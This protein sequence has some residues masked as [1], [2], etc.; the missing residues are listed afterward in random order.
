MAMA[1]RP[2]LI[3]V[4]LP[5]AAFLGLRILGL[6]QEENAPTPDSEEYQ[7]VKDTALWVQVWLGERKL[8]GKLDAAGNF[9]PDKRY[10]FEKG[11]PFSSIPPARGINSPQKGV[12]EFRSGR[13]IPG[14][15]DDD[16]NFIPTIGGRIIDFKDYR[17]SPKAPNYLQPSREV[18]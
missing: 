13:L 4:I 1:A 11:Q 16:G 7:Y 2:V 6:R 9:I 10:L 17:Y 18:R 3:T 5:I 8:I 15:I 12:Y 14:D